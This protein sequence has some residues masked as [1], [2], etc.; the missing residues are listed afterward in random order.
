[1]LIFTKSEKKVSKT[2][3]RLACHAAT[4]S[5][6]ARFN[7]KSRVPHWGL[8]IKSFGPLDMMNDWAA[9]QFQK[10]HF[11]TISTDLC[12]SYYSRNFE[13][14]HSV[15]NCRNVSHAIIFLFFEIPPTARSIYCCIA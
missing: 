4:N 13:V 10:F 6:S 7:T 2:Q 1:M 9:A 3:A 11:E 14:Q 8:E 12:Q 5:N 15:P